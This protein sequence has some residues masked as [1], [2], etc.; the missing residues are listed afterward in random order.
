[1][2]PEFTKPGICTGALSYSASKTGTYLSTYLPMSLGK[3]TRYP[4]SLCSTPHRDCHLIAV[5]LTSPLS[6]W[7]TA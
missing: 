5:C 4:P 1:M 6:A 3:T 7:M 2:H